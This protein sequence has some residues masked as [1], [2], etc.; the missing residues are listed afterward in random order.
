LANAEVDGVFQVSREVEDLANAG[1]L[2]LFHPV[3]DPL[4]VHGAAS[5][6]G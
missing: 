4:F 6:K 5:G 1:D 2:D 3:R